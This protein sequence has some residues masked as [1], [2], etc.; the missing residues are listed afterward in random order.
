MGIVI[1]YG[2]EMA[3]L[4]S[5]K[6]R[7]STQQVK[8]AMLPAIAE[9]LNSLMNR[10]IKKI[11]Q[12]AQII[13]E[14]EIKEHDTY[15]SLVSDDPGELRAE[16]GIV[17]AFRKTQVI[18]DH[19]VRSLVMDV[20][21]I[22]AAGTRLAGGFTLQAIRS[23]FSDVIDMDEAHHLAELRHGAK[24]IQGLQGGQYVDDIR[25]LE[26]LLIKGFDAHVYN[27]EVSTDIGSSETFQTGRNRFVTT[28]NQ[29]RTG[30]AVM[31]LARGNIWSLPA[32]HAGTID[33]N[34]ITQSMEEAA[35][36]IQAMIATTIA[37]GVDEVINE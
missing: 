33:D 23:N 3:K 19:W 13:I 36:K 24:F 34:W 8:K 5:A 28:G 2:G 21:P 27:F 9:G 30:L 31:K 18:I 35:A 7:F 6:L 11:K 25:W 17:D 26:W 12:G 37:G 16:L 15:K 32:R 4:I 22:R 14:R 20:K 29:S 1:P 10:N